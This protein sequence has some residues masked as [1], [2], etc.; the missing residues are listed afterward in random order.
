LLDPSY[1]VVNFNGHVPSNYRTLLD[2]ANCDIGGTVPIIGGPHV[3]GAASV[4]TE[5]PLRFVDP[6][7]NNLSFL[8]VN[9]RENAD[10]VAGALMVAGLSTWVLETKSPATYR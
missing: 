8:Q 5:E 6:T 10:H 1:I 3:V 2:K 4:L 9:N 7:S